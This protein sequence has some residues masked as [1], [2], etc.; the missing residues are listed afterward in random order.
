LGLRL[1]SV[2]LKYG[3]RIWVESGLEKVQSS[4]FTI[5]IKGGNMK[6]RWIEPVTLSGSKV[7]LEPLSLEHLE[8]IISAVK[9]GELWNLWFTSV[10]SPEKTEGYIKTA[11]DMRENA[12]A[13]PYCPNHHY[14]MHLLNGI[15]SAAEITLY[16]ESYQRTVVNTEFKYLLRPMP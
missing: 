5:L 11:L 15:Q 2:L 4:Y 3:G 16:S 6:N 12:G 14:W 1:S 8:G 9:D 13:M 10:P 7:V